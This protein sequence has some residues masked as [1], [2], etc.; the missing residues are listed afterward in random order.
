M[1]NLLGHNTINGNP[2]IETSSSGTNY[3][4]K[5]FFSFNQTFKFMNVIINS[6]KKQ[7]FNQNTNL[8]HF[9]YLLFS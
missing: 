2:I 5:V 9:V 8:N 7:I 6:D 3:F 1:M 4:A